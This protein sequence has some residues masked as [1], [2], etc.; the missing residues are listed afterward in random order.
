MLVSFIARGRVDRRQPHVGNLD[1]GHVYRYSMFMSRSPRVQRRREA[2]R[3]RIVEAALALFE[4][5]GFDATTVEQITE[6]ADIGKGTFFTHFPTKAGVFTYLSEHVIA[7]MLDA[8]DPSLCAEERL[9]R[10]FAAA[11]QWFV[12]HETLARPMVIARLRSVDKVPASPQRQRLLSHLA[13]VAGRAIETGQWAPLP[14]EQVALCLATSYFSSVALWALEPE[15][16]PL[17]DL[18]RAQLHVVIH[19]LRAP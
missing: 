11:A 9:Q 16:P 3:H 2:T 7:E 5:Q 13:D 19:G 6:A 15:A 14:R 1:R 4:A 12:A 10:S 17:P 18:L 8:D